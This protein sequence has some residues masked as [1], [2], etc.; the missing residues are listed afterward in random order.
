VAATP[1]ASTVAPAGLAL[2]TAVLPFVTAQLCYVLSASA[3]HIPA[4]VTYLTGCT[5]VSASGRHGWAFFI[6][7]GGMIPSA[8]LLA[9]YWVLARHWLLSLGG[10]DSAALRSAVVLGLT[11]AAFYILYA[12]FVGVP[13]DIE[14]LL[15][16]SGA[17]VHL[18]F[19]ALAQLVFVREML[20]LPAADRASIPAWIRQAKLAC[21]VV[22]VLLTAIL[23]PIEHLVAD[24]DAAQN[25]IEWWFTTVMVAF[26]V[27][28]WR[29]WRATEFRAE[30]RA[31]PFGVTR[32]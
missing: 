14:V 3:G 29:A 15:R 8:M 5:S 24:V 16:R 18:G 2:A 32:A 19:A 4:C 17:A 30:L 12:L 22:L 28:S 9:A 7:K 26:Y 23:V 6:Y 10:R 13:G 11:S 1:P 21:V 25:V 31:R 20:R 27:L